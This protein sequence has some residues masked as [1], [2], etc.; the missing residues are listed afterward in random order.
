MGL[1]NRLLNRGELRT[2]VSGT[3]REPG[4]WLIGL[5]G[6][7]KSITGEY[8]TPD[9]ALRV[10]A[11]YACV[12]ILSE[13]VASLPLKLMKKEKSG[14]R[15]VADGE[16]LYELLH[17]AP[18]GQMTAYD[19]KE[20]KQAHMGLRGNA[21]S[22]I[23]RDGKGVVQSLLPQTPDNVLVRR[24]ADGQIFYDFPGV[25]SGVPARRV[26]HTKGFS[27]DGLVGLNP[28]ALARETIGLA[29]T[30]EKA[31]AEAIGRG[32]VP[33]AALEVAGNPDK[34][35]RADIRESWR[36]I[37]SGNRNDIAVLGNG[38]KLHDLRIN[39]A[40]LQFMES[41]KFQ[42]TEIARMFR[43]PPHMLADLER[44]T[45]NNIEHQGLEFVKY[46]LMP[47][48]VR[49]EQRA[50]FSLLSDAERAE[51]FYFKFNFDALLRGDVKSRWEAH[52]VAREIG[53][54]NANEIRELEDRDPYVGGDA[55]LEP[56]NHQ[57]VGQPRGEGTQQ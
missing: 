17:V 28:I 6:G 11:V 19:Y 35:Q 4:G 2:E 41:R 7:S 1:F 39:M 54:L 15:I 38:M 16:S 30:G 31:Q 44:S 33:P 8:V 5:L 9:S 45:N 51:G 40:D 18:N 13:S 53:A 50:N 43:I 46:T 27:L 37:H 3:S 57:R 10:M 26:F 22:I 56:L 14:K 12:R 42:V 52:R 25:E 55:Y 48:L 23:E 32:V 21:Y 47:W 24:S 34:K 36:E 20:M 29:I 49:W